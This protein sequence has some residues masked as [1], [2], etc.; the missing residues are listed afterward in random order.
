[1]S[2]QKEVNHINLNEIYPETE[3]DFSADLKPAS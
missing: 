1:M 2:N 3:H